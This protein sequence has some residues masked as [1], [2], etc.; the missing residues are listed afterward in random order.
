MSTKA[1]AN[2]FH[3][4]LISAEFEGASLGDR[5]LNARLA[6]VVAGFAPAPALSIPQAATAKK[7]LQGAYRFLS[8]QAVTAAAILEPHIQQTVARCTNVPL[9]IVAHDTTQLDFSSDRDGLGYTHGAS[10]H[11]F[12]AHVSL[13]ISG[14]VLR[15]PL[16]VL[17]H[18]TW[19]RTGKPRSKKNG[20]N[21]GGSEYAKLKDRESSRWVQQIDAAQSAAS[22]VELLH[23]GDRET[24]CFA[25]LDHM[26]STSKRFVF[27]AHHPRLARANDEAAEETIQE[28][29]AGAETVL[30]TEVHISSRPATTTPGKNKTFPARA[31]RTARLAISGR[32]AQLHRP[33][34]LGGSGWLPINV[35]RVREVDAPE[36]V[37]PIEWLLYTTE[38]V[39]TAEQLA[40]VVDYYRARWLIEEFFKA[41]KTGCAIEQRQLETFHGLN[42]L[43]ALFLPMAWHMLLLRNVART[44][45]D[46]PAETAVS[47]TQLEVLRACGSQRLPA[48]PTA[49]QA[50]IALAVLGGYIPN[51]RDPG[52]LV[53]GRGMEKLLTLEAGWVAA[54]RVAK[55]SAES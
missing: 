8:N 51:K 9:V 54:R 49:R 32:S 29:T 41:L 21:L 14:D 1:T 18:H 42:N 52:W 7:E 35:V 33:G 37:Q 48:Q 15:R 23:V 28:L 38:P 13:A 27:R 40:A 43:L 45:P 55:R 17:G 19:A 24:D 5:R 34:Y 20:R 39:D 6:T 26:I 22:D 3:V 46:A 2:T 31:S 12:F 36:G 11:G 25:T 16:G 44:A 10:T 47:E 4:P 30:E 50:L 53:L